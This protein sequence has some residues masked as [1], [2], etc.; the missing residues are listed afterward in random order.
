MKVRVAY[1]ERTTQEF[2]AAL[3]DW[4]TKL[5]PP[6]TVELWTCA[7]EARAHSSEGH[8]A[9]C[10]CVT[11]EALEDP[12]LYFAAGAAHPE[13]PNGL[14]VP[15]VLDLEPE[16]LGGTPFSVFQ[17]AR[18]DREGLLILATTFTETI[19]PTLSGSELVAAFD[20]LWPECEDR[21]RS[22]PGSLQPQLL[23]TIATPSFLQTFPYDSSRMDGLWTDT[24]LGLLRALS[25][26]G[27]P[28][29]FPKLDYAAMRLLDVAGERRI[30][31]PKLLSRVRATHVAFIDKAVIERWGQSPWLLA[32]M[33][34]ARATAGQS[35]AQDPA[36]GNF[37]V[38]P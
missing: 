37:F 29:R 20:R 3:N 1:S 30:E 32:A 16:D 22:V 23:V 10:I 24:V 14:A 26:P 8:A 31:P 34:R 38:A 12:D 7:E 4:L 18:A 6:C 15:V 9:T 25:E 27:S 35:V 11:P 28:V 2:A 17:A 19:T 13:T 33:V 21:L 36:T 5:L